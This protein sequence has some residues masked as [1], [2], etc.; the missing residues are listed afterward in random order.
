MEYTLHLLAAQ[1]GLEPATLIA[2]WA[3]IAT[4]SNVTTRLIPDDAQGHLGTLRKI[5]AVIGVY[6]PNRV[7]GKLT[8]SQ[9]AR[10][11]L[12]AAAQSPD[13]GDRVEDIPPLVVPDVVRSYLQN[14]LPPIDG[15]DYNAR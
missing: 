2:V 9:V 10:A 8:E 11:V 1:L 3:L 6:V 15:E 14:Q 7:H 13:V 5:T 4:A 12:E